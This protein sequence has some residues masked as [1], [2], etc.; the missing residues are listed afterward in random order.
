MS[1][2]HFVLEVL[3]YLRCFLKDDIFY[4]NVVFLKNSNFL[5]DERFLL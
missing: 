2:E 1:W 4:E 3:Y 5:S